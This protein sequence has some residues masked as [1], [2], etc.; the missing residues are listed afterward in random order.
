MRTW[1]EVTVVV[2]HLSL[3][4]LGKVHVCCLVVCRI[5]G[6]M[7]TNR[8]TLRYVGVMLCCCLLRHVALAVGRI[9][10]FLVTT[11]GYVLQLKWLILMC[12]ILRLLTRQSVW[13]PLLVRDDCYS[14]GMVLLMLSYPLLLRLKLSLLVKLLLLLLLHQLPLPLLLLSKLL[15]LL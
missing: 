3:Q 10:H 14:R 15:L 6:M 13:N 8:R 4:G 1:M 9:D 2:S 5:S 12:V 7:G 11:I